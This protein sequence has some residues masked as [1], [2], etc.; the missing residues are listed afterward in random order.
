MNKK[1]FFIF[2]ILQLFFSSNI[3]ANTNTELENKI[4]KNLRCLICQGQSIYD[5]QSDFAES[6]KIVVKKKLASG[7]NENEIYDFL[8]N[9]YGQWILYDP[10][11]QKNTLFLW[12]IPLFLFIFGGVLIFKKLDVLKKQQ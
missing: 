12:L 4:F 3:L 2:I 9:K 10:Q 8:K 7:M 1:K 5:S 6:M 11:F